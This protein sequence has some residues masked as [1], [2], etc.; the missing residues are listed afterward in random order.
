MPDDIAL[1]VAVAAGVVALAALAVAIWLAVELR[2][3]RSAQRVLLPSGAHEDIV[4]RQAELA[5]AVTGVEE[6]LSTVA[7]LLQQNKRATDARLA[8]ALQFRG[9]VRYDA[10]SE[11]GGHQSWSVA[12]ID[13]RGTGAVISCL[14]ARDHARIYFK[15]IVAGRANQ[16]LSPEEERAI[17]GALGVSEDVAAPQE[18]QADEAGA[19]PKAA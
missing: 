10:Y 18:H 14:H 8:E 4:A 9:L 7:G 11:T 19:G 13:E 15:E 3:V 6:Q 16:R 5:R 12:L 1:V 2:R 17:A